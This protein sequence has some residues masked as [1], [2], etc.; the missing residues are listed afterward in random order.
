MKN[1]WDDR[2]DYRELNSIITEIRDR[3]QDMHNHRVQYNQET[4]GMLS[5]AEHLSEQLDLHALTNVLHEL[6]LSIYY[7][8]G[9]AATYEEADAYEFVRYCYSDESVYNDVDY[10]NLSDYLS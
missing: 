9:C 6:A 3:M 2:W 1:I 4:I 5:D 8:T 10:Y 7:E